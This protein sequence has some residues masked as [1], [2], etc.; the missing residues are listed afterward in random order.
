MTRE[1]LLHY[2][3]SGRLGEG[4]M[5]V[6]YQATDTRLGREVAIKMLPDAFVEDAERLARFQREAQLLA[7]LN[8]PNVGG[9]YGLEEEGAK[10]FLVLE[11][12]P[13]ET[14]GERLARGALPPGEALPV[15][16]QL[17]HALEAAHARGIVHRDLKPAN[18][19]LTPDGAV[20]VLDFGLAKNWGQA[21]EP[22][23]THSPTLTGQMTQA[24]VILG[25]ASYMSP[26]QARGQEVDKR[27]DIWSFGAVLFEMLA[28]GRAFDGETVTDILGAIVHKEPEWDRL[29]PDLPR[30]VQRLLRRCLEKDRTRRLQDVGDA[31][32]E[33]EEAIEGGPEAAPPRTQRPSAAGRLLPWVI[34]GGALALL[35]LSMLALDRGRAEAPAARYSIVLP[36]GARL[37]RV[38]QAVAISPD[39]SRVV[40]VARE[41]DGLRLYERERASGRSRPIEGTSGA[42]QVV[43]SPDGKSIAFRQGGS[44]RRLLLEGGTPLE[45]TS[46]ADSMGI[47][48]SDAGEIVFTPDWG[49]GLRRVSARGGETGIVTRIDAE[50]KEGVH[51]APHVLPGSRAVLFT[52]WESLGAG[53]TNVAVAPLPG[54]D[55]TVLIEDAT[56]PV[57]TPTGHLLF[58]RGGMLMAVP[59]DVERLKVTGQP[60]PVQ[61]GVRTYTESLGAIYDVAAD[62][63]LVLQAGGIF[64]NL[65]ELIWVTPRGEATL[66]TEDRRAFAA[67]AL[68]PDGRHAAVTIE[69]AL[70]Q[71]WLY[72]LESGSRTQLTR[73][74]D[75]GSPSWLPNGREIVFWSALA[76]PYG[77]FRMPV[78]GSAE[79]TLVYRT[80]GDVGAPSASPRDEVV[81]FE[82][83]VGGLNNDLTIVN[84]E[85]DPQPR[86]FRSTPA[87]EERPAFSP[88]GLW[89]AYQSDES[90][91]DEIYVARYPG[92]GP[93]WLVSSEGGRW[94]R[95]SPDGREIYYYW[96][97]RMFAVDVDTTD[98]FRAQ[99]PRLLFELAHLRSEY[100]VARDRDGFLMVREVEQ[101]LTDEDRIEVLLNWPRLLEVGSGPDGR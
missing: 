73:K 96:G 83:S 7:A 9:I 98:G 87:N 101:E 41:E 78:D 62:G 44:I 63:T 34:A 59:F 15:A 91:R 11:L 31:R 84:L 10:R 77:I 75:N 81:V 29:P 53:L 46:Q 56:T 80:S 14:L 97:D 99:R 88:D 38:R 1:R 52:T 2:E 68:A 25:T 47:D 28:G 70:F 39:G 64:E 74:S 36:D 22:G 13:G 8:H 23:L 95:W 24:G 57:Y 3:I 55:H 6:V 66:A 50:R 42:H 89:I 49:Y 5:G 51:F 30:P 69:G 4:G 60:T 54:G 61:S 86:P 93:S 100:D 32:I 20:K 79:P 45:I 58:V 18:V 48:W 94:P 19:K 17:A 37:G 82:E 40:Y 35:A 76:S 65:S 85:G 67:L 72:D 90:R 12:I 33:I 71:I 21:A 92:P 16:L 43:F 27:A 26:E